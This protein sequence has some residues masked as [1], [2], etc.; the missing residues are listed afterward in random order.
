MLRTT[1]VTNLVTAQMHYISVMRKLEIGLKAQMHLLYIC[2]YHL[3]LVTRKKQWLIMSIKFYENLN[4]TDP[5]MNRFKQPVLR[6]T[7]L[8][9]D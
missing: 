3:S 5:V 1:D 6:K 2:L 9:V 7:S 4:A 8:F